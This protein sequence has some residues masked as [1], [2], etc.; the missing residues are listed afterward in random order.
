MKKD[1]IY[2]HHA[3]YAIDDIKEDRA[4]SAVLVCPFCSGSIKVSIVGDKVDSFGCPG[5]RAKV[6]LCSCYGN[7]FI[8]APGDDYAHK[9][10]CGSTERVG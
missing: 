2:T 5:C 6:S 9:C 8:T 4:Y 7:L 3:V 10:S 1:T